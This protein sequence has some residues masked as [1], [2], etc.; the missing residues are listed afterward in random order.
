ME[1]RLPPDAGA[2]PERLDLGEKVKDL[3][4]LAKEQGYLTHD[5]LNEAL[6]ERPRDA[7]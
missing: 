6:P 3:I 5:D 7:G 1:P 2:G 4:R